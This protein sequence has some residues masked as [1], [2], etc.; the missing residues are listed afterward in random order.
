MASTTITFPFRIDAIGA[1]N[2]GI[3]TANLD[4]A[5]AAVTG[6]FSVQRNADTRVISIPTSARVGLTINGVAADANTTLEI[7][8]WYVATITRDM[9]FAKIR[10]GAPASLNGGASLTIGNGFRV[11]R[12]QTAEE[13]RQYTAQLVA[14]YTA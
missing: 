13:I 7:G 6:G 11:T 12:G 2:T 10:F 14:K 8:K 9:Q 4:T 3:V 1:N 5:G